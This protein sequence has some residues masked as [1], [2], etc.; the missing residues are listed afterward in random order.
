MKSCWRRIIFILFVFFVFFASLFASRNVAVYQFLFDRSFSSSQQ[1]D[2]TEEVLLEKL[3]V[4]FPDII[5][6]LSKLSSEQQKQLIQQVCRG[7]I[8]AASANGQSEELSRKLGKTVAI[9]LSK[10]I[11]NSSIADAYF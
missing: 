2:I 3:A 8:A 7:V 6:H 4:S 1:V 9:V 10:A 11:S 5:I